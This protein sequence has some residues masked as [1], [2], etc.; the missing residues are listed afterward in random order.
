MAYLDNYWDPKAGYLF[1]PNAPAALRHE[2][3]L[4]SWYAIGLL[5][6]NQGDDVLN[7]ERV[8]TDIIHGQYKDPADQW[9]G[10]YQKEP[11]EPMVGSPVYP[12]EIYG[13][14]DPNWRGFIGTAMIV[15]MEEYSHLLSGEVQELILESLHNNTVGDSYREGGV[16]GDNLYP[17]YSN[18]VLMRAFVSGWTGRRLNDSN[19]TWAG[20][21]YANEIIALFNK[22][23]TL[24][25]FNG[26]TY[27][28]ISLYALTLWDMYMPADSVLKQN[29]KR[30]AKKTYETI[31][32]LWHP[33]MQN[34]AGPWDRTFGYDMNKYYA[35]MAGWLWVLVGKE[36]SSVYEKVCNDHHQH[37]SRQD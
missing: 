36:K 3:R 27:F 9:Y 7:A 22:T 6:R 5:A 20:E 4:S 24:S 15:G 37:P 1:N 30:M 35:V 12:A 29:G 16:D 28:G 21:H 17:A 18:P 10:T 32:E 23:D 11:E 26:P 2:T 33:G 14:W 19:M 31:G 8:L 13:S 34:L 25:E